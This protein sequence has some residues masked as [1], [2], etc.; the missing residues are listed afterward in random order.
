MSPDQYKTNQ[1]LRFNFK[2]SNN[3]AKYEAMIVGLGLGREL[4]VKDIEVFSDSMSI[5]NK[6]TGGIPSKR[7]ANDQVFEKG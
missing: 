5:V 3:E 7:R 6:V 4:G 2:T 1:V